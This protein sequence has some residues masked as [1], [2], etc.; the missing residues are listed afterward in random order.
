M[1]SSTQHLI[2]NNNNNQPIIDTAQIRRLS[3]ANENN[4]DGKTQMENHTKASND[5]HY[6]KNKALQSP[7]SRYKVRPTFHH[8]SWAQ[9]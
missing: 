2:E 7:V 4:F 3:R 1:M 8:N 9:T 5:T 6:I